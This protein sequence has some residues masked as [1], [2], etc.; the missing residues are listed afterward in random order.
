[1]QALSQL[2]YTPKNK[3]GAAT[4]PRTPDIRVTK[5]ALCQLS[6]D[7]ET[8]GCCAWTCDLSPQQPGNAA[9]W[10][11]HLARTSGKN[12]GNRE[13]R[14]HTPLAGPSVFKTAAAMPIRL[15]FPILAEREGF[16]PSCRI[17]AT[18]RFPGGALRPLGQRSMFFWRK[19]QDSNLWAGFPTTV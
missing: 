16:E 18:I 6:Y 3:T 11:C 17:A 2:S 19:V 1:M 10:A 14:T 8:D 9:P 4:R 13:T 15:R 12:G 7:G 5:A